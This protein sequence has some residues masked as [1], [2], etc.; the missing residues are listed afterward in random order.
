GLHY[1]VAG[2]QTE[3][4]EWLDELE[5]DDGWEEVVR[6]PS[7]HNPFQ[8]KSRVEIKRQQKGDVVYILC[9]SE[10]REEKDRAIRE[11]HEGKLVADLTK[12]QQRVAKGRLKNPEKIH[13]AIGR[14]KERYPRVARCALRHL[15]SE[16]RHPSALRARQR[17]RLFVRGKRSRPRATGK[18]VFRGCDELAYADEFTMQK[19]SEL[20]PDSVWMH[21]AAG[22]MYESQGHHELAIREYR[23]V[24]A[25]DPGRTGVHFRLGRALLSLSQQSN[26]RRELQAEASQAFE[27]ELQL[28]PTNANAAY[29][30]A[31]IHRKWGQLDKAHQ[32]F[33]VALKH[34]P[35]F[36]EARTDLPFKRKR[37]LD[38]K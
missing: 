2:R 13:Q 22:D 8:K 10:G 36:E 21:Q 26:S 23:K 11:K 19:L 20:A 16:E 28:D 25:L 6:P 35:D 3:R 4:N 14:L 29:E 33:E 27:Q 24:L 32:F 9:R 17:V 12:L 15:D 38:L 1:L 37:T 30:L 18:L 31:E 34:Y 5:N 7:P